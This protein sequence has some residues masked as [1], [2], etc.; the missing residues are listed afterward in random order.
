VTARTAAVA[1][2][3]AALALGAGTPAAAAPPLIVPPAQELAQL[4]TSHK[5]VAGLHAQ[6]STVALLRAWRPITGGE[7]VLPVT[8]RATT[9][10]GAHWLRVMVPGRPNERQGWIA[11]RGTVLMTTTW[12]IVVRRSARRVLVFRRGRLLRSF[13]AIVGKPSTPTPLGHFFVEESLRVPP[14]SPGGPFALATSARSDVLQ[15]FEGGPGQIGI[16]GLQ[17]LGGVP[18]TAVSHGCVRITNEN[19]RWLAARI[20][21]GVPVTIVR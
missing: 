4:L 6:R 18:G 13:V 12:Q 16:H 1:T 17:N 15:E 11:A 2:I 21:P 14:G 3:A 19:I 5:V 20:R 10:D 7:T 9:R 8:G